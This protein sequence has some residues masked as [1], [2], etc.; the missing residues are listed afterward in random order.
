MVQIALV[1]WVVPMVQQIQGVQILQEIP[2]MIS[3][4]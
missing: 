2:P 3:M 1:V 4:E